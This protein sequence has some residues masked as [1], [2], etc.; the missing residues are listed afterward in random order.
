MSL[1]LSKKQPWLQRFPLY[2]FLFAI[3]PILALLAFNISEVDYS[4]GFRPLVLSILIAGLLVLILYLFYHDWK[5]AALISTI[6]LIL[7]FSYGH[8][9][10]LLKGM[11][12]GGIYLF[13]HRT[14][15]PIWIVLRAI[16]IW[17]GSRKSTNIRSIDRKR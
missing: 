13:R 6:L 16:A 12:V 4:S 17:W 14:L 11:E 7:F 15:V 1:K 2:P 5:R 3:Y 8:L 10:L 9:Y